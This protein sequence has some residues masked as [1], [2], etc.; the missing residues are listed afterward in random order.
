MADAKLKACPDLQNLLFCGI[1]YWMIGFE[2]TAAKFFWYLC[3]I[4]L[5]LFLMTNCELPSPPC[6]SALMPHHT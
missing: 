5:T 2:P 4:F 1:S 6:V 3:I